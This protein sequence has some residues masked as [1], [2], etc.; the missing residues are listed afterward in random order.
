[1]LAKELDPAL[2]R[3]IAPLRQADRELVIA[4]FDQNGLIASRF[5][6]IAGVPTDRP[7]PVHD[8][9]RLSRCCW[10]TSTAGWA[11]AR[12]SAAA[13]GSCRSSRR[14]SSR[15]PGLPGPAGDERRLGQGLDHDHLRSGDVVRELLA[16]AGATSAT[17]RPTAPTPGKSTG[18]GSATGASSF[19]VLSERRHRGRCRGLD[20]IHAA[21]F[22]LEDVK[23]GNIIL[24]APGGEPIFVDLERALPVASLPPWLADHLRQI[25][26][27]KF[28]E[29]FGARRGDERASPFVREPGRRAPAKRRVL[30]VI[31]SLAGGG[32]ERVM[33]TLLANSQNRLSEYDIALAVLDDGPRAFALPD[34]SGS[35]SWTAKAGCFG[36]FRRWIARR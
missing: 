29:H 7:R 18:S 25:D 20:A 36:A 27:R 4:D 1:M 23:F 26:V 16:E 22:V 33:A 11:S 31:N 3:R 14:C 12:N 5:G 6:K 13:A 8:P 35:F 15:S 9:E 17:G 10:S 24:K 28:R 30:F 34:G 2:D 19:H 32:A 21:G